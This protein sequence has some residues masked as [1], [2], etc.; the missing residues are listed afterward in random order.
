MHGIAIQDQMKI[1]SHCFGCGPTNPDGLRIKSYWDGHEATCM[2]TPGPAHTAGPRHIL[3]GGV[4]ATIIDCHSMCTA[5]AATHHAEGRPISSEPYIW[6]VTASLQLDY[7]KPTPL[8]AQLH[9]RAW[10]EAT[11]GRRTTVVCTLSSSGIDRVRGKVVGVRVPSDW[12]AP[13]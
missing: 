10:V 2:F 8:D 4:I 11:D 7:L 3:N 13:A 5:I 6:C 12:R 1:E 9:L